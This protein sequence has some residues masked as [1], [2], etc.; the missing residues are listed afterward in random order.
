MKN[1]IIFRVL[2]I[3]VTLFIFSNS[4]KTAQVSSAESGTFVDILRAILGWIGKDADYGTLQNIVRKTAHLA[5]FALQGCLLLGCFSGR[6]RDR[7]IYVLFF[8]L[9][10]SC[11]DEFLQLFFEGRGSQI[12]DVFIDF[13]G[14]VVGLWFGSIVT[15]VKRRIK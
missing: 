11:T 4:L 1:K 13:A 2:T 15:C 9:L 14:T 12:Q 10:T 8:G 7:L 3:L 5:E 6:I